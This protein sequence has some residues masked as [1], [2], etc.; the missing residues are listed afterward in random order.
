MRH[1]AGEARKAAFEIE[2]LKVSLRAAYLQ[3]LACS[4]VNQTK[5]FI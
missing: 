1:A 2:P 4:A 3:L 5:Q